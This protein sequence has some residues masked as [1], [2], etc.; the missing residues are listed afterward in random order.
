MKTQHKKKYFLHRKNCKLCKQLFSRALQNIITIM[1]SRQ[2]GLDTQ[3]I[4]IEHFI[5]I[6]QGIT[7]VKGSFY[8]NSDPLVCSGAW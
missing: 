5:C 8:T 3:E 2:Q 4:V 1:P 7:L 6:I